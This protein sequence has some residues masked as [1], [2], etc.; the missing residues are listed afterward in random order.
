MS[1][2]VLNSLRFAGLNAA[3]RMRLYGHN[4]YDWACR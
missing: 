4:A 2:S 3:V 1:V